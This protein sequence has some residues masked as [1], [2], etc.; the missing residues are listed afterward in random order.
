MTEPLE[1]TVDAEGD[2][3]VDAIMRQI[4]EYIMARRMQESSSGIAAAQTRFA[5]RF[6]PMV[7]ENLYY[8]TLLHDHLNPRPQVIPSRIPLVGVWLNW[9][10]RKLHEVTL[11]YTAQ[12]AHKQVVVNAHLI[13][14]LNVLVQD[15]EN[16]SAAEAA[17]LQREIETLRQRV[18]ALEDK[19]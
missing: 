17:E 3:D 10:R 18:Q 5:G 6:D 9:L 12:L 13:N 16:S 14:A 1:I 15:L 2:V 7:Y 4:R 11:F 19:S 8:A